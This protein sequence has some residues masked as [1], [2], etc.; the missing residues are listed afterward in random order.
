M[1]PRRTSAVL[2]AIGSALAAAGS[3]SADLIFQHGSETGF[4]YNAQ[5]NAP[6]PGGFTP[7]STIAFTNALFQTNQSTVILNSLTF[8]IRRLAGAPSVDLRIFVGAMDTDGELISSSVTD[9]GLT[10]L[11]ALDGSTVTQLVSVDAG[12]LNV[13]LTDLLGSGN[14]GFGGLFIG[15]RFEGENAANNL[16]GWRITNAPAIGSAFNSFT[17]FDPTVP[18]VESFVFD[19]A[20]SYL[21]LD[22][23]GALIPAPGAVAILGLA[24][25]AGSR[26]RRT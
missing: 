15:I 21:Y 20:P 1:T 22:I 3:A 25:I 12:G 10:S 2:A 13:A 16:N 11:S 17:A 4:R 18:V 6:L 26:R 9:L 19:G 5:A 7:A 24:G 8:G 23:E 14:P